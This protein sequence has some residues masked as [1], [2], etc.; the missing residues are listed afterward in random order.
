[1]NPGQAMKRPNRW[2]YGD[3]GAADHRRAEPHHVRYV[4]VDRQRLACQRGLLHGQIA[5]LTEL[6]VGGNE[7]SR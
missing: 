6:R 4:L 5:R 1:M 7:V 2:R 3:P